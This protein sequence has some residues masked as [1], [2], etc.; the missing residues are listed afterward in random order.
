MHSDHIKNNNKSY[1]TLSTYYV[2]GTLLNP[3]AGSSLNIPEVST[4]LYICMWDML[5]FKEGK[6]SSTPLSLIFAF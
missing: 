1:C 6:Y 5:D 4:S 2:Q 3:L